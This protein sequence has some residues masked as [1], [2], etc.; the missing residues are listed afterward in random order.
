[1]T[2]ALSN[3]SKS[4][5][6]CGVL[7]DPEGEKGSNPKLSSIPEMNNDCGVDIARKVIYPN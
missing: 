6:T 3:T 4:L 7:L 1:M 2:N 5:I